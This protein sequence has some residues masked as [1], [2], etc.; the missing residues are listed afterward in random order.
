MGLTKEQVKFIH[1]FLEDFRNAGAKERKRIVKEVKGKFS[2]EERKDEKVA[3]V[4][5][6]FI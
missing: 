6:K 1:P 3:R 5:C 4:S 2:L